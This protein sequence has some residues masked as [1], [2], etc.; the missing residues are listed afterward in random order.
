MPAT[1]RRYSTDLSDAEWQILEPLLPDERPGGR[2]RLYP[3][4]EIINAIQYIL[5]SGCAWRL[6]P[7]DLPHWRTAY[8]YFR[9][10]K[11]DGTWVRIHDHLYE[12]LRLQMGRNVQ[13]SAA[14]IDSQSIKTTEKGGLMAT[15]GRRRS[16]AVNATFSLIQ[17]VSWCAQS[18]TRQT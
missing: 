4:R 14:V 9:I 2:H 12:Q 11:R 15:T 6:M 10:W 8:E 18:S 3:M 1:R 13:P 17:R 7:H 16:E 5:R